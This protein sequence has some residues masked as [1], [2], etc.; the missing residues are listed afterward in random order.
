[1]V[2]C[3]FPELAT[4]YDWFI[5]EKMLFKEEKGGGPF[6]QGDMI[7]RIFFNFGQLL[8]TLGNYFENYRNSPHFGATFRLL[9]LCINVDKKMSWTITY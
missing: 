1:M 9:R 7:G 3:V 4:C 6:D 8:L 5:V 2:D